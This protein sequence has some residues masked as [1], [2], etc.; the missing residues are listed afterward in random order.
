MKAAR[1]YES[2][3]REDQTA[4]TRERILAALADLLVHDHA[5]AIV[6]AEVA[7]AAG[8][9]ERTLYRHFPTREELF[10]GVFQWS[11]GGQELPFDPNDVSS[12]DQ[13]LDAVRV[14][15]SRFARDPAVLRALQAV[16]VGPELRAR[17][18]PY[19]KA[20]VERALAKVTK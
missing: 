12:P 16:P 11:T 6:L 20:M 3:L 8:V 1:P 13:L 9:S 10:D 4:A 5:S 18:A 19:R 17:R 2:R 7:R 15:F 14:M